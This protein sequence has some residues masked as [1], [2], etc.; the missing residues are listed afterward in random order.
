MAKNFLKLRNRVYILT[1][2]VEQPIVGANIIFGKPSKN[3]LSMIKKEKEIDIIHSHGSESL[4]CDIVTMHSCHKAYLKSINLIRKLSPR[5]WITVIRESIAIK[6]AKLII[7]VSNLVKR[8][9]IKEYKIHPHKI[10]VIYNGVNIEEFYFKRNLKKLKNKKTVNL[11]FVSNYFLR[12]G[13]R[14]LLVALSLIKEKPFKLFI[15]GKDDPRPYIS[16]AKRLGISKKIVFLGLVKNILSLYKKCDIFV[17]PT[18]MEPFGLVELEAMASGLA[19][20]V[21]DKR[22]NGVVEVLSDKK[23]ALIIKNPNDPLEIS[24]KIALLLDNRELIIKLVKNSQRIALRMDWG[25]VAKDYLNLFKK[26]IF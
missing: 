21:S 18:K 20:I 12:K 24:N 8:Q 19:L 22:F 14:E 6:N 9:I 2:K 16:L 17:F 26:L 23:D 5:N 4:F 13:L 10:K 1:K 11:L 3:Y 7:A 15:A 25:K